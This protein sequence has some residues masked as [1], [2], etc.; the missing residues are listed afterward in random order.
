[1]THR[2]IMEKIIA[3]T[4]AAVERGEGGPF[5]AA[6]VKDGEI[7]ATGYNRCMI[8]KDP[9]AHG[10]I[11][12]IRNSGKKLGPF[13]PK[14]CVLYT[15]S[16]SCPMCVA[17]AIWAGIEKIYMG[18]TS[19]FGGTQGL[20]DKHVYEYLRGNEDPAVLE[21]EQIYPE[22]CEEKLLKWWKTNCADTK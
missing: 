12:A 22:L 2:E 10:E 11:I 21:Q 14:G 4:R 5:G 15:T 19:E 6:V 20:S 1:M 9:T 8:D 18:A 16:Q 7:I 17:A 3:E 13:F